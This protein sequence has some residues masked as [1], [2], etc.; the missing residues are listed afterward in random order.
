MKRESSEAV[1]CW[2]GITAQTVTIWRRVLKVGRYTEGTTALMSE[3]L[4]P[5][6]ERAREAARPTWYSPERGE[7]IS[8]ALKGRPKPRHVV[9][10]MRKGRTGKPH[11]E[12]AR[13]KMSQASARGSG[14]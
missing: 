8:A 6:L 1:A 13:A 5:V 9:E 14:R 4:A 7:K 10:A 2:W 11:D 12:Q 3:R